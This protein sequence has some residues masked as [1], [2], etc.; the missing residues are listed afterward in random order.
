MKTSVYTGFPHRIDGGRFV[1]CKDEKF[2]S[3]RKSQSYVNHSPDGFAWGYYGSGCAQ[4]ALALLLEESTSPNI[5]QSAYQD[6]KTE[7]IAKLPIAE[8]WVLD[9]RAIKNWLAVW[10]EK[11]AIRY[12]TPQRFY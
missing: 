3:P 11:H 10:T 12:Q 4:L 5:A 1:V 6:F 2:L 9:S 7:I 8:I